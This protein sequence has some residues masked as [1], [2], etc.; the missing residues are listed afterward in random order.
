MREGR[1][2]PRRLQS[3]EPMERPI[4]HRWISLDK[5]GT[6][7]LTFR[8]WERKRTSGYVY[9]RRFLVCD[10]INPNPLK[11]ESLSAYPELTEDK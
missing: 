6:S 8:A 2:V 11:S 7:R 5:S 3:S 9:G 1:W 10:D 4:Q